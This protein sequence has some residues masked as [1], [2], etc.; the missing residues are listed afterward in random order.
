MKL[1]E[2][3]VFYTLRVNCQRNIGDSGAY[4]HSLLY[5]ALCDGFLS[6]PQP[7]LLTSIQL[8]DNIEQE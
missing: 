2:I 7:Q 4:R 8:I 6:L 1:D 5:Q 3:T